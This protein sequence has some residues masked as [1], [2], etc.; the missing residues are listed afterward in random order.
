[1]THVSIRVEHL[2]KQ[3]HIGRLQQKH[4]TFR[5]VLTDVVVAPF[6]RSRK[7]LQG[8]ATGA[9]ELDEEL[10]ALVDVSFKVQQGELVGIIGRN[11]AGKSTLLK[12]LSRI[13]EPTSG[14][15]EIRGRVSSLLEVGTGFHL[16]LT[17]RENVYLNGAILGM[18]RAEI[19]RKFDEIV[20]FS[21]VERFVDTPIKHYSSGMK[22][23]LAFAVAAHLEPEILIVDE[24]LAVGDAAFQRKC[25][26]KMQDVG[27]A[28]RTVLFVSHNMAAVSRLCERGILLDQG[29]II[30]D[31]PIHD[32]VRAYLDSGA[33]TTASREW[34]DPETAPG[35][36]VARIQGVYVR[37]G[38][39]QVSEAIDIRQP[40]CL[41]MAYEV[42]KEGYELVPHFHLYNEEGVL[43]FTT[44]DLDPEWRR[45]PRPKGRYVSRAIIPG[46]F[47]SEGT[48]YVSSNMMTINPKRRQFIVQNAVA[49]QTIDSIQ[50]DTARGDFTGQ[51]GGIIRPKLEWQ[52]QYQPNGYHKL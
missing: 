4:T 12:I 51:L 52:T 9:S 27:Q 24:V 47:L 34:S 8:Q 15:A 36:D 14:F 20:A 48:I 6:R 25:V 13:T 28:G 21:E 44:L 29:R 10:W 42:L 18:K 22:M 41:E 45:R 43:V 49:F 5:E 40:I 17:G 32:V 3:Y 33:G 31:A 39:G 11:G 46:N 16:E 23:R 50:G 1:M 19:D 30:A 7:L 37:N 35:G 26:S 2:T 38:D